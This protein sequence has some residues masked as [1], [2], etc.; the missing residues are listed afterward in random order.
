MIDDCL[1]S[2]NFH[3]CYQKCNGQKCSKLAWQ[4]YWLQ[5]RGN[6][7]GLILEPVFIE[8]SYIMA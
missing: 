5:Y 1:K 7:I 8:L 4:D 2:D 3:V 6:N